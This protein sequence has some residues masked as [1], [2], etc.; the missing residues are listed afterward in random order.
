MMEPWY[1][2]A[3]G[4]G[5]Q[6]E[7]IKF[8]VATGNETVFLKLRHEPLAEALQTQT[9]FTETEWDSFGLPLKLPIHTLSATCSAKT[10]IFRYLPFVL[11]PP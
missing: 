3:V 1:K 10:S 9:E 6:W 7:E 5:L 4:S 8:N 11:K 2:P